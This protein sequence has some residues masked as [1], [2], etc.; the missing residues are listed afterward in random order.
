M[1][2]RLTLGRIHIRADPP[3]VQECLGTVFKVELVIYGRERIHYGFFLH[4]CVECDPFIGP[5]S[6]QIA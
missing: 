5:A 1:E 3:I 4:V 6:G 2:H